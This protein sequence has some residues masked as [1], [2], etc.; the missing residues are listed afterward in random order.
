MYKIKL[1]ENKLI[2]DGTKM[3]TF[4][5]P[6][7][8]TYEAGM[9][10]DF[11]LI[12]PPETD[13]EGDVRTFSL[14]SAPHENVIS[15]ATRIRDTAFKRVLNS[16]PVGSEILIDEPF[17]ELRLPNSNKKP[18]VF[19]AG[20]IGITPFYSMIKHILK[21]KL[22]FKVMLFYS[23]WQP[24]DSA[25]LKELLTIAKDEPDITVINTFTAENEIIT[26]WDGERGII[27]EPM[28]RKYI[29]DLSV[30]KYYIAGPPRMV[31]AMKELLVS[32]GVSE[33]CIEA[34]DFPGY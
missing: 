5:K 20:G 21:E 15:I 18:L 24:K 26:N 27:N 34:E 28:L 8:Y 33:V 30:P 19:I 7:D 16:L 14:V 29:A 31:K 13:A 6:P 32:L 23:N 12:D 9:A 3:F 25:F 2:A 11:R 17:G 1:L 4:E 22:P 10:A